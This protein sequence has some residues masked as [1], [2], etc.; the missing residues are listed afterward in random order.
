MAISLLH[1]EEPLGADAFILTT[2]VFTA[3]FCVVFVIPA[4][5]K[6]ASASGS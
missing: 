3:F 4:A 6:N 1:I 2:I 5:V